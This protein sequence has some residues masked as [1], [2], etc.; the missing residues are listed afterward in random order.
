EEED[1]TLMGHLFLVAK[2][3]AAEEGLSNG[4]RAVINCGA[5][6]GQTVDHLHIHVMGGRSLTWPPG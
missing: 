4:W 3:V 1:V 2:Q 5:E 6:G